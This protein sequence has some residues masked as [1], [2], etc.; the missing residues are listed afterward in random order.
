M[1]VSNAFILEG[2][3]RFPVFVSHC[4]VR[5]QLYFY[6]LPSLHANIVE[7]IFARFALFRGRHVDVNQV[8]LRRVE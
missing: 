2:Y 8:F 3:S 7:L 4:D 1:F 5:K 6:H